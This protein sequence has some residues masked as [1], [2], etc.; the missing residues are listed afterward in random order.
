MKGGIMFLNSAQEGHAGIPCRDCRR[1]ILNVGIEYVYYYNNE[2]VLI[3]AG[4]GSWLSEES[5]WLEEDRYV[6]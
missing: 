1:H 5:R 4:T 2:G 3:R 6:N